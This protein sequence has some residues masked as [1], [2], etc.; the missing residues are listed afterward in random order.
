VDWSDQ[1]PKFAQLL[2]GIVAFVVVV[3]GIMLA[4]DLLPRLSA[5]LFRRPVTVPERPPE[6]PEGG[7]PAPPAA[8]VVSRQ[9][10]PP[11]EL[12][13]AL[14][15]LGPALVLVF[16]GLVVPVFRTIWL[17]LQDNVGQNWVGLDNYGWMFTQEAI[18]NV[19]LNT[20]IWVI[21]APFLATTIGLLFGI[22]IDRARW[23]S[24]AKSL[25]FLPMAISFVGA[26]IIWRFMYEAKPENAEQIGFLNQV[27]VWVGI[28][29]QQFILLRG[30]HVNTLMLI[31]IMIWVQTGF[32]M[33]ILSAAIK[34]IPTEIVEAAR[35]DGTNPWQ[36]FWQ[37]TL[38][39]IRPT[40]I[41]VVVTISI[42]TLKVFDIIRTMTGGRFDTS[43]IANE[44]YNQAFIQGQLGRGS[45]LAAFL[46]LLVLPLV[47]Y[48]VRILRQRRLEGAR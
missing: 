27:L 9:R 23:E 46:F 2:V 31:L 44:M 30:W 25:I 19:L 16:I 34:A 6:P 11:R 22:L 14:G 47:W 17:S 28:G 40:V 43:V 48:Q 21:L 20:L 24:A 38:P 36:M 33:V 7:A 1:S 37:V 41:V 12:W 4:L 18:R 35:I 45:A 32:A 5:A 15:F 29:P 3:G 8:A 42:I 10:K 13:M 39:T 26:T